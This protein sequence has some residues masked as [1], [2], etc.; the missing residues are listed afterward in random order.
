MLGRAITSIRRFSTV[1]SLCR[2][3]IRKAEIESVAGGVLDFEKLRRTSSKPIPDWAAVKLASVAASRHEHG[4][5]KEVLDKHYLDS[6]A[7]QRLAR[8][9]TV[10]LEQVKAALQRILSSDD[11]QSFQRAKNFYRRL[12]DYRFCPN[13]DALIRIFVGDMMAKS[14]KRIEDIVVEFSEIKRFGTKGA[15]STTE[16]LFAIVEAA[17]LVGRRKYAQEILEKHGSALQ[18]SCLLGCVKLQQGRG[19]EFFDELKSANRVLLKSEVEFICKLAKSTG[20]A[21]VVMGLFELQVHPFGKDALLHI[22]ETAVEIAG[23][24]GDVSLLERIWAII[25]EREKKLVDVR[26]ALFRMKHF[27]KCLNNN[28]ANQIYSSGFFGKGISDLYV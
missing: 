13:R 4:L 25:R 5:A 16:S 9:S 7:E 10:N 24:K 15:K 22:Y 28:K 21:N 3:V 19:I 23:K 11:L 26:P 8:N 14:E 20:K 1:E 2:E 6:G 12:I 17:F 27:F 18:K